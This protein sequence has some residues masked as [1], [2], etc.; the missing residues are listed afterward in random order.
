MVRYS[1]CLQYHFEFHVDELNNEVGEGQKQ[2]KWVLAP[3][4]LISFPLTIE[5]ILCPPKLSYTPEGPGPPSNALWIQTSDECMCL[6]KRH[7]DRFCCFCTAMP[8]YR[9]TLNNRYTMPLNGQNPPPQIK[10]A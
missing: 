4:R 7:L 6:P 3:R 8:I 10:A 5:H 9:C 2:G 1:E